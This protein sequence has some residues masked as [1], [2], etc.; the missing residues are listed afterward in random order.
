MDA[1]VIDHGG[2][3][4]V[5]GGNVAHGKHDASHGHVLRQDHQQAGNSLCQSMP[6][7]VHQPN[8]PPSELLSARIT[9]FHGVIERYPEDG[10]LSL[11]LQSD[12]LVETLA[13]WGQLHPATQRL[14]VR[15][16]QMEDPTKDEAE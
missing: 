9:L 5:V 6:F 15:S 3:L 1:S 10:S 16:V 7:A 2:R 12:R 4:E 8:Q 14:P 13:L 11:Y